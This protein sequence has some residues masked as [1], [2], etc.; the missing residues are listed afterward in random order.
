MAKDTYNEV[1]EFC[2][3]L[4][5]GIDNIVENTVKFDIQ[6]NLSKK[7]QRALHTFAINLQQLIAL[8]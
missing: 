4:R 8:E 1:D 2:W 3:Q 5:D 7:E 6:T